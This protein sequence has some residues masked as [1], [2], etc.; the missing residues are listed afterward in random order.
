MLFF[1]ACGTRPTLES[2]PAKTPQNINFSGSWQLLESSSTEGQNAARRAAD[3]IFIPPAASRT[4]RPRLPQ[5]DAISVFLQ[6]GQNLKITQTPYGVFI[7]YDRSVVEEYTFGE[8]RLV[9]VGPIE[10]QRVSGWEN[11]SFVIETLDR[12]G[13]LL[14]ESWALK[15]N[16]EQL[17]RTIRISKGDRVELLQEELFVRPK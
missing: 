11:N 7:S 15:A 4:R 1:S 6:Y 5:G 10:A 16:T 3:S 12:S 14:S 2:K 17:L 13:N 9:T 8:N